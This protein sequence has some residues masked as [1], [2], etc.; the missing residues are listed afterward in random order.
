MS[1]EGYLR[2]KQFYEESDIGHQ[3]AGPLKEGAIA[4]VEIAN[5]EQIYELIKI[6]GRSVFRP[7]QSEKADIFFRFSEGSIS[8]L[9]DPPTSDTAEYVNRLCECLLKKDRSQNVETQLLVSMV[10]G[11]RKGYISMIK[12]GGTRALATI[13]KIG[14]LVPFKYLQDKK[15]DDDD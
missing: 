15:K 6:D 12:L 1:S 4:W 5:D 14:I 9:F 7:K 13:A 3:L 11:W 8:Y 10:D 2:F